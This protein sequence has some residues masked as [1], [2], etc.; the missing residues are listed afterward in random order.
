ML[1]PGYTGLYN[2]STLI[3][4]QKK[5]SW[6]TPS[7]TSSDSIL[8]GL[9]CSFLTLILSQTALRHLFMAS[10]ASLGSADEEEQPIVQTTPTGIVYSL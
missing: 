8:S 5:V 1:V 6:V 3:C 2:T 4:A 7:P 9:S 10:T